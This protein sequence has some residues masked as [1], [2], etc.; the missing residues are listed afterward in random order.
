[1]YN[2]DTTGVNPFGVFTSLGTWTFMVGRDGML[3]QGTVEAD[4]TGWWPL[5]SDYAPVTAG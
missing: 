2:F 3:Y 1:M 5:G 4:F